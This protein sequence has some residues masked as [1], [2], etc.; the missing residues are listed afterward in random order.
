MTESKKRAELGH[1]L[2]SAR[3][4]AVDHIENA[5]KHHDES[6]PEEEI[7]RKQNRCKDVN[8]EADQGED[9]R[10]DAM[11][12]EPLDNPIQHPFPRGSDSAADGVVRHL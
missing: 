1:A 5:G 2:W 3:N 7:L 12:R 10:M 6:R 8:D 11:V 9:V 4:F